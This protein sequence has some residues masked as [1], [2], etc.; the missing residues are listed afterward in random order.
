MKPLT[1]RVL[2]PG[3]TPLAYV[4][5]RQAEALGPLDPIWGWHSR[6]DPQGVAE[7]FIAPD[8]DNQIGIFSPGEQLVKSVIYKSVEG[9]AGA[10]QLEIHLTADETA[11]L[12]KS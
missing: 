10:P 11:Q 6:T 4:M 5:T 7:Q 3:D 12:K 9:S 2:G 8:V 1:V